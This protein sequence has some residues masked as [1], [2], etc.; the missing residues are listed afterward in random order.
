M[1]GL[2]YLMNPLLTKY[3]YLGLADIGKMLSSRRIRW[4]GH[5]K[6]S[7]GCINTDMDVVVEVDNDKNDLADPV[8]HESSVRI[9]T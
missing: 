3:G 9:V 4:Y 1:S 5:A 2:C 8:R 6:R 7:Q